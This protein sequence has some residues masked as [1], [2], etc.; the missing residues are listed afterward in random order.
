MFQVHH[1]IDINRLEIYVLLA[2]L[3][4]WEGKEVVINISTGLTW[5]QIFG[6][7][8]WYKLPPTS[9]ITD[10]VDMYNQSFKV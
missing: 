3:L 8:Y 10:T 5:R 4:F 1:Y 2:G 7:Y 9:F 6:L